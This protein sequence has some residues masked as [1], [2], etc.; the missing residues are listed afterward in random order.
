MS[1]SN[2]YLYD[3]YRTRNPEF[4][5][6]IDTLSFVLVQLELHLSIK[7]CLLCSRGVNF[8]K[9]AAENRKSFGILRFLDECHNIVLAHTRGVSFKCFSAICYFLF[10]LRW[11]QFCLL[12]FAWD[13]FFNWGQTYLHNRSVWI[14]YLSY[15][16]NPW[17][18]SPAKNVIQNSVYCLG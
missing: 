13:L 9:W 12:S 14:M 10:L 6:D 17:N 16:K 1:Y 11:M 8:F 7:F 3:I 15:H 2:I 18:Q 4:S 5:I